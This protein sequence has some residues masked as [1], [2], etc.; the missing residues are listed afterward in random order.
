MLYPM[1]TFDVILLFK[2]ISAVN[3]YFL[4]SILKT[5]LKQNWNL[6]E[7]DFLVVKLKHKKCKK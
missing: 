2:Y 6:S 1:S 7:I 4:V 5:E 3:E